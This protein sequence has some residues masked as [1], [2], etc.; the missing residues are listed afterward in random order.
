MEADLSLIAKLATA[1]VEEATISVNYGG[2]DR[3]AQLIPPSRVWR[4]GTRIFIRCEG[5]YKD[6][7]LVQLRLNHELL[8]EI[9]AGGSG[10]ARDLPF[11]IE[12]ELDVLGP[13][14]GWD[15]GQPKK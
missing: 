7:S 12:L 4:E 14:I 15:I 10:G 2:V 8:L 11:G 6:V 3:H 13:Q 1:P 9:P 5:V